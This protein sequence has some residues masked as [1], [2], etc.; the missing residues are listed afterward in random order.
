ME[1]RIPYFHYDVFA[2]IVPGGITLALLSRL[3]APMPT[4]WEPLLPNP[5]GQLVDMLVVPGDSAEWPLLTVASLSLL[6]GSYLV[7]VVYEGILGSLLQRCSERVLRRA[8]SSINVRWPAP[9]G[10]APLSVGLQYRLCPDLWNWLIVS[11]DEQIMRSAEYGVRFQAEARMCAFTCLALAGAMAAEIYHAR[12][13]WIPWLGIALPLLGWTAY[14]RE[15]HR[16][17]HTIGTLY[18]LQPEDS[19]WIIELRQ[20]LRGL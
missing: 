20:K 4:L 3:G 8:A 15:Y 9:P 19:K 5:N 11:P 18:R 16:W 6:A 1:W 10:T 2:R 17:I 12:Y 13:E 14:Q 7:G